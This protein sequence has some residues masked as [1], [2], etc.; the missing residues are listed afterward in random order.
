MTS[1]GSVGFCDFNFCESVDVFLNMLL[2]IRD[3]VLRC[4]KLVFMGLS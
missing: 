1:F 4:H 3:F 2:L